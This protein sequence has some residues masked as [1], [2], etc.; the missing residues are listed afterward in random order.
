MNS[1]RGFKVKKD[2]NCGN[3]PIYGM[4]PTMPVTGVQMPMPM[5]IGTPS[6][7]TN[8]S[9]TV[10]SDL[11]NINSRLNSLEQRVNNLEKMYSSSYSSSSNY[12]SSN[13]QMM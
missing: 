2:R 11:S 5:P 10:S 4:M 12:N 1:E 7:N 9:Y 3:Y 8:S 13:Y 6:Y